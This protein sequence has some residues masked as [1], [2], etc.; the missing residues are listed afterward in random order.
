[1]TIEQEA[2]DMKFYYEWYDGLALRE[3]HVKMLTQDSSKREFLLAHLIAGDCI[4]LQ[5]IDPDGTVKNKI[6]GA[7]E[8]MQ[9]LKDHKESMS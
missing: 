1:M 9:L 3:M 8:I 6:L 7:K 5:R 4:V 2:Q